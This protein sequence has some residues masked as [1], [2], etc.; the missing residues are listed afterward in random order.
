MPQPL[1][2]A[3]LYLSYHFAYQENCAGSYPI[4]VAAAV[5][6]WMAFL[7]LTELNTIPKHEIQDVIFEAFLKDC[8]NGN[9]P[10]K[11]LG[12]LFATL[13]FDKSEQYAKKIS[14]RCPNYLSLL[15][16]ILYPDPL[17]QF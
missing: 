8:H 14:Q 17:L 16:D 6:N 4:V 2:R 15:S 9:T 7:E 13:S 11:V 3:F 12:W 1:F 5:N 10:E